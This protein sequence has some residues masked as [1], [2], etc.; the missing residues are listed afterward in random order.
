[1]LAAGGHLHQYG[2]A[3]RLTDVTANEVLWEARPELDSARVVESM[4][5]KYFLPFGLKLDPDHVYRLTAEYD[6]PTGEVIPGGGMGALGGI[7]LPG[8]GSIWPSPA[9]DDPEY[10][11]DVRLTVGEE[12]HHHPG[13]AH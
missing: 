9:H 10:R 12:S 2:T 4:P 3:L 5:I 1:M 13:H 8:M 7:V 11:K 6:N